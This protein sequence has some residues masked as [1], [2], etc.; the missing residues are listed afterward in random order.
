MSKF[1]P[2]TFAYNF[3]QIKFTDESK[4]SV[5]RKMKARFNVKNRLFLRLLWA[6]ESL[7]KVTK[8]R[9][10]PVCHWA[11][12]DRLISLPKLLVTLEDSFYELTLSRCS[13]SYN[14]SDE[15][16]STSQDFTSSDC[17][18]DSTWSE[19]SFVSSKKEVRRPSGLTHYQTLGL[20]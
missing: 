7:F 14:A 2:L 4:I 15:H 3:S 20:T 6:K 1:V 10:P 19:D 5:N 16:S 12:T 17:S 18:S 8:P 9:E 13:S 11:G